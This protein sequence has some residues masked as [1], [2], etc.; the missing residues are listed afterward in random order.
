MR[1]LHLPFIENMSL[2]II[3]TRRSGKTYRTYQCVNEF[4]TKGLPKENICRIQFNDVR[5]QQVKAINLTLIDEAYYSLYPEKRDKEEILFIFDE[6]HRIDGWE[7]YILYLLDNKMHK[8][9]VT[10]STSKLQTGEISSALRGKNFSL[11]LYPFSF[12][13]FIRHRNIHPDIITS[14]GQSYLRNS[15]ESYFEQGGFPGLLNCPESLHIELL[16]NYW[17]T[18]LLRDIIEAHPKDNINVSTLLY[19]SQ[20]LL[21]RISC[22]ITYRKLDLSMKEAGFSCSRNTLHKYF[23]YFTE[24]FMLYAIPIYTKSERIRNRN[25][26]KIYAIDWQLAHAVTPG[27]GIDLMRKF[28][29]CIF[30]E[31][32]RRG[33]DLYYYTTRNG[34]EIDFI[35]ISRKRKKYE[36]I[37]A[38]VCYKISSEDVLKREIRG[39]PETMLY[40]N[41][42]RAFI[43]TFDQEDIIK[44]DG[45]SIE[46]IPAWKWLVA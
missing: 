25:Y 38:Q 12:K 2:S 24:A 28:E 17:Q 6:I 15:F 42:D 4:V 37:L 9:L 10:G 26:Q 18:M 5:F 43:I 3:G 1:D 29:N 36:K 16:Q 45:V 34:F 30:I 21:S 13:E 33:Y 20:S 8:V 22:P 46:I 27:E 40:L 32:K 7:D 14:K 19:F 23:R 35:A 41:I 39:I 44:I 11:T 31:L